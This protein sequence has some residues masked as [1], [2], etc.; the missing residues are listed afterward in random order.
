MTTLVLDTNVL[1]S[2]MINASGPPGHIV[3]LVREG[4]LGLTVD[5]RILAEYSEVLNRPKFRRYFGA[6]AVRDIVVYLEHDSR[7]V[8]CREFVDG[9]P[10]MTDAPFLEVALAAGA[11]LVTGNVRDYPKT[12]RRGVKVLTPAEL[13]ERFVSQS[14][15][16]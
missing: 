6:D 12:C 2:G 8:V 5:D 11:P 13:I 16:R 7:Y 1:I 3:D 15:R 14:G 9:L 4:V 10:D